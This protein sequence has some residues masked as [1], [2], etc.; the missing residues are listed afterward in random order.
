MKKAAFLPLIVFICL[1]GLW[2]FS[3]NRDV[4]LFGELIAE[5][6]T[7]LPLV[8]LTFDDGPSRKY[9]AEVIDILK[10]H[11]TQATFFV[12]GR[13]AEQNREEMRALVT[14]GHELGNHSYSHKRMILMSPSNVRAE[15]EK[16]D[17]AIRQ[18]G[19]KGPITFRPPYGTRLFVLPWV[20]SQQKRLSVMWSVEPDSDLSRTAEQIAEG[21]VENAQPGSI[22]LLHPM[23]SSRDATR[24]ALGD[25]I[26]G[27]RK[28]GLKPVTLSQ[29][30]ASA[31]RPL[32]QPD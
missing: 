27:L 15:L 31:G 16:T 17:F 24:R 8:A 18:A 30:L 21:T 22:I 5:V 25:I 12:T 29:L 26:T 2:Q 13:E 9:T 3:K 10:K 7:D 23:Y 4:Q 20:L 28:K 19:Y 1:W 11:N 6:E 32:K 14:A